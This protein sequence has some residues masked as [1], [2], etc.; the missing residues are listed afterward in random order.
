M[1]RVLLVLTLGLSM[2]A[3]S[4]QANAQCKEDPRLIH[5][6]D[7]PDTG[8]VRLKSFLCRVEDGQQGRQI[9]VEFHRLSEVAASMLV[10]DRASSQVGDVLGSPAIGDNDVKKTYAD[11]LRQFG[12]AL[13]PS[14]VS[15]RNIT[16]AG[17]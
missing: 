8:T 11:L 9:R 15:Y 13:A 12:M 5:S 2:L 16:A 17:G 6:G 7:D 4:T 1:R 3:G 10:S 14:L